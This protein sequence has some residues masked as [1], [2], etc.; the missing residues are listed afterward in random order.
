MSTRKIV[1]LE[2]IRNFA[3]NEMA[4]GFDFNQNLKIGYLTCWKISNEFKFLF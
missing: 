3:Y 4:D 1:L 2:V